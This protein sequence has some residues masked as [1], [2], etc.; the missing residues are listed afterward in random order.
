MANKREYDKALGQILLPKGFYKRGQ[1]FLRL[2][3]DGVLQSICF[4][5]E[6]HTKYIQEWGD[7]NCLSIAVHSIYEHKVFEPVSSLKGR[8]TYPK[9]VSAFLGFELG[10][11]AKK[12][13]DCR[14]PKTELEQLALLQNH[15]LEVLDATD[16]QESLCKLL[17]WSSIAEFGYP[18]LV[19]TPN[20]FPLLYLH[21]YEDA[22][23]YCDTIIEQNMH[24][25]KIKEE[26]LTPEQLSVSRRRVEQ[27]LQL[28]YR[29]K[30]LAT[31]N[32]H[33]PIL[34]LLQTYQAE[35]LETMYTLFP[36][37]K[38]CRYNMI[39]VNQG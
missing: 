21:R 24:A 37:A 2:H 33:T 29:L 27:R 5:Y 22:L 6:P 31:Q 25:L 38:I 35:N 8:L 28:F 10:K 19:E 34:R 23:L 16:S 7:G 3:G 13:P 18:S 20:I 9:M 11:V 14:K 15:V 17:E 1:N 4:V 39:G 12:N 30:E 26:Y 32:D 36:K